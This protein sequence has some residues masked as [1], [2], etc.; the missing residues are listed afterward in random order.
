MC[1]N[2]NKS[3]MGRSA[4]AQMPRK[5]NV[6]IVLSTFD[7][8]SEGQTSV[9]NKLKRIDGNSAVNEELTSF[10]EIDYR[11]ILKQRGGRISQ[12]WIQ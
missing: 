9:H 10:K 3:T 7:I 12:P 8:S 5:I 1:I 6:H 11:C 2:L 4:R